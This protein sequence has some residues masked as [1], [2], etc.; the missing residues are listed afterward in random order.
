VDVTQ[1]ATRRTNPDVAYNAD[2]RSG[3]S[4]LYN[5]K[6]RQVGGT[7]AGAPQWAALI[8]LANEARADA[9]KAPLDGVTQTLPALYELPRSYFYDIT[10]G[11]NRYKAKVGYDL[12]TG[13]GSPRAELIIAGLAN[14]ESY[15]TGSLPPLPATAPATIDVGLSASSL[16]MATDHI[17]VALPPPTTRPS[18]TLA[19][20]AWQSRSGPNVVLPMLPARIAATS[21][22]HFRHEG[23]IASAA[24]WWGPFDLTPNERALVASPCST[25]ARDMPLDML[26]ELDSPQSSHLFADCRWSSGDL[27]EP[28]WRG[29]IVGRIDLMEWALLSAAVFS[30]LATPSREENRRTSLQSD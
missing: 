24:A 12:V 27:T 8:A 14:A 19:I 2:P 15:L 5:G 30:T 10:V 21:K 17:D 28:A 18:E 23:T 7:S 29:K 6:W 3:V 9:G 16:A 11:N 13:R 25:P 26:A 4:V 1:S 22:T 20:G